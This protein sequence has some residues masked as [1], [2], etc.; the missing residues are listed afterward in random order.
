MTAKRVMQYWLVMTAIIGLAA[1]HGL[2]DVSDPTLI[3]DGDIANAGGANAQRLNASTVFQTGTTNVFP[4]VALITDEWTVDAATSTNLAP[5]RNVQLD[6]RQSEAI[7]AAEGTGDYHLGQLSNAFWQTSIALS[8][9]RAYSPDSLRG[10]FLGQLYALRGYLILQMA[11]DLCSGFPINDVA[12]NQMVYG[13][14]L[15]TDSAIALANSVLDSAVKYVRDSA[16][17]VT[18]ARVA[19]GR[20]LLDQGQYDAAAAMV[21]SVPTAAVYQ[22]EPNYASIFMDGSYCPGCL[23]TALGNSEGNNGLPF[24]SANDPRVPLQLLGVRN[25]NAADTLYYTTKNGPSMNYRVTFASGIEARLIQAEAALHDNQSWKPILDSLRA[26][27]G[28]DTLVDPGTANGR[29]DLVY[30]ERAFWLFMTGRRLGDLRRLIRNYGR[31]PEAVFPS[32]TWKG[33]TGDSYGTATSI[34]FN[35]AN[36]QQYNPHITSGCTSR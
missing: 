2:L 29:V 17:F 22:T 5:I 30:S 4:D 24:V 23:N 35:L 1:C 33:G 8:A 31:N 3:R 27:V 21:A 25:T 32:G 10:D 7:E 16:R 15:T 34:P 19:K 6:L 11:E 12:D 18:L 26:T 13:G 9:V 28:L 14:P 36:E 20:A